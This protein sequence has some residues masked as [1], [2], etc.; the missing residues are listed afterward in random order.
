M[1]LFHQLVGLLSLNLFCRWYLSRDSVHSFP[2]AFVFKQDL[3]WCEM[4]EETMAEAFN[5]GGTLLDVLPHYIYLDY[6]L[7]SDI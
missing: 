2:F 7:H 6:S 5:I 4:A 3:F 1:F